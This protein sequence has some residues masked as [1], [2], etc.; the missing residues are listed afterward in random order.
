MRK[1]HLLI[2]IVFGVIFFIFI[3]SLFSG[4][5]KSGIEQRNENIKIYNEVIKAVNSLNA[6]YVVLSGRKGGTFT[7]EIDL[8]NRDDIKNI[9]HYIQIMEF[10]K[11]DAEILIYCNGL[12]GVR[13]INLNQKVILEYQLKLSECN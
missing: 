3:Y 9:E 4:K 1:N 2:L 10:N 6:D 13:F 8:K 7:F 11:I 5:L 12:R